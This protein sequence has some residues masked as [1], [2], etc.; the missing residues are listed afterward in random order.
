MESLQDNRDIDK[1]VLELSSSSSIAFSK[2]RFEISS[3][4]G[5]LIGSNT[6]EN[7]L[8]GRPKN[9]HGRLT[10]VAG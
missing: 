10:E 9:V 8:S 3:G 2:A 6:L 1:R 4:R 5:R 7:P